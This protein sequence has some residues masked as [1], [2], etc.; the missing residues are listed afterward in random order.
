MK[1]FAIDPGTNRSAFVIWDT[2]QQKILKMSKIKLE[3]TY[4]NYKNEVLFKYLIEEK[5]DI[6]AIEDISYQGNKIGKTTINTIKW[7]GRYQQFCIDND[8]DVELLERKFVKYQILGKCVG[9]DENIRNVLKKIYSNAIIKGLA[10]H[11]WQA[12]ALAVSIE[13][14][15]KLNKRIING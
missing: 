10:D 8:I 11:T 2:E 13:N 7:I 12:F 5:F 14:M 15:I 4:N 6:C 9:S 3:K 1:I